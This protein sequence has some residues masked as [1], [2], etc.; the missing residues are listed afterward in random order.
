MGKESRVTDGHRENRPPT[1]VVPIDGSVHALVALPV[2]RGLAEVL[3]ATLHVVHVAERILPPRELL[4]RLGVTPEQLRG[5]VIHQATGRPAEGII[6][7]ARELNSV[8]IVMCTHTGVEEPVGELGPIAL[9]VVGYAPCPV[10]LVRPE[11]GLRSW[12]LR[13]ILLPHDGTPTTA[14]AIGPAAD[15]AHRANAELLVL[16]VAAPGAPRPAEPGTFAAPRYLDQPQHEWPA[17]TREFLARMMSLG[18]P[19]EAVKMRLF[20]ASG[21][22]GAEIVRFA[23]A[24]NADLIVL[25]WRGH[26]EAE[27]AATIKAVVRDTPCPVMILRVTPRWPRASSEA[28]VGRPI[29]QRPESS[30]RVSRLD[31]AQT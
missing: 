14:A 31:R 8:L 19:P 16:H 18:H 24:R 3:G 20:L 29:G 22:P 10:V 5:S 4:P 7:L 2:A 12:A 9:E 21:D 1:V 13:R 11:R 26:L 27:R 6:L 23:E 28:K 25:G 15:L 17:W 30:R